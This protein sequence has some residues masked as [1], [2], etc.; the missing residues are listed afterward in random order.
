ML[1]KKLRQIF[2]KKRHLVTLVVIVILLTA[3]GLNNYLPV[4]SDNHNQKQ[5]N[6]IHLLPPQDR[7]SFAVMGDNK[8][9]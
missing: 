1:I 7:F 9:G 8:S 4:G 3:I 5:I 6:K 2:S